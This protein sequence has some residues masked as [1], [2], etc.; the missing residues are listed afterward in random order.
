MKK[1]YGNFFERNNSMKARIQIFNMSK[2]D[3]FNNTPKKVKNSRNIMNDNKLLLNDSK[4]ASFQVQQELNYFNK[5]IQPK[6]LI[7]NGIPF[8]ND[9]NSSK[10]NTFYGSFSR[11][12]NTK[13]DSFKISKILTPENNKI[14]SPISNEKKLI[15][16]KQFGLLNLR[17]KNSYLKNKNKIKFEIK[18][19]DSIL[20]RIKYKSK[21]K[22]INSSFSPKSLY[23]N[24]L[25]MKKN[26]SYNNFLF[27]DSLFSNFNL[28]DSSIPK[29]SKNNSKKVVKRNK[30]SLNKIKFNGIVIPNRK[31]YQFVIDPLSNRKL[32]KIEDINEEVKKSNL[33]YIKHLKKDNNRIFDNSICIVDK[34]KFSKKYQNPF[35]SP[36]DKKIYKINYDILKHEEEVNKNFIKEEAFNANKKLIKDMEAEIKKRAIKKKIYIGILNRKKINYINNKKALYEKIKSTI[37]KLSKYLKN[38]YVS[39]PEILH[40]F[41]INKTC[42]S[43]G[44]TKE[45]IRAIKIGNLNTCNKLLDYH[46]YIV[47]DYD[48]YYLTPLHWATKQN[49]FKIIPNLVQYGADVNF[50]NFIGDTPLQIGVKKNL[51][52]CVCLLLVNFSSPFIKDKEGK[53][54]LDNTNDFRMRLVLERIMKIYYESF[55]LKYSDQLEFIQ[56]NFTIFIVEEFSSELNEETLKY[57]KE[58]KQKY[59]KI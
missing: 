39:L 50:Q 14:S 4:N 7:E 27:N 6:F 28:F 13:I 30:S 51:Y 58:K 19:Y 55:F 9:S 21:I 44:Q 25:S 49:L 5:N 16:W 32:E 54:P 23:N 48:F 52:E 43:F 22:S 46:K 18:E 17:T 10:A 36:F 2:I 42:F 47:L 24:K 57:F 40:K 11:N 41:K 3:L 20:G 31:I 53:I 45:L 59:S 33:K 8:K 29:I 26:N 15:E 34:N 12:S 35:T 1:K 38:L 37:I 56:K